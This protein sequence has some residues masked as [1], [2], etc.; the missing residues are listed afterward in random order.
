[1]DRE[2]EEA[3]KAATPPPE[4][5]PVETPKATDGQDTPAPAPAPA[6]QQPQGDDVWRQR[7]LTLEGKYKAEVPRLHSQL[8]E[9][10]TKLEELAARTT[11]TETPPPEKPKAKRVTEKDQ[12]TFGADL[13][14]VI[15]R[16]AEEIAAD[17]LADL[18]AKVGKLESE[19]EQLKAQVTGVSQTQSL[20]AQEVYF[21]KL[22]ATV[23]D[24]EAINVSPGFLDWLG[25]VD[26]LS[27]ETRQAYL[28]RAFNSLNVAQTAKLFNAY[29]K[30]LAPAPTPPPAPKA[31][32]V[33]R[34]VAPGK[35]KTPPGPQA[36]D[37]SSKI[38]S[39]NEIDKFYGE[40]RSG[41]YRNNPQE[42]LRIE[43][44]IDAAV[45]SGRVKA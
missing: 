8:K 23:P 13:L 5:P 43:A 16:Q 21:G 38:W 11:R 7:Y 10:Q 40:V 20:T 26:E 14:D 25:E 39:A 18:Q 19:N 15:K 36:S 32:E 24:W 33:Q 28:D 4:T 30:T 41:Y 22:A 12:E 37:A 29:K 17:A 3:S 27:G 42:M 9:M 31:T 1:M 44:E 34:Q 2:M 35:S 6:T 45:A